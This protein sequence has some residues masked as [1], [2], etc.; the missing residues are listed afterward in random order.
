MSYNN[1][2][3]DMLDKFKDN[4]ENNI[5]NLDKKVIEKEN[6]FYA[7]LS[8]LNDNAKKTNK[9]IKEENSTDLDIQIL[10][11]INIQI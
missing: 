1:K 3:Y 11:K 7:R 4:M 6:D 2:I 5:N 10:K 8:R 9:Y